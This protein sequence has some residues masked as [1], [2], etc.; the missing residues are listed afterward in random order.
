MV[1]AEGQEQPMPQDPLQRT[2]PAFHALSSVS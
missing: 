2:L 1:T